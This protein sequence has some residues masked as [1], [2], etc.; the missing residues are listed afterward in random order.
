MDNGNLATK[1]LFDEIVVVIRPVDIQ[2][3][4]LVRTQT[5][6]PAKELVRV[7]VKLL[8]KLPNRNAHR[9]NPLTGPA[10]CASPG[11]MVGPQDMKRHG[12]YG[13]YAFADPLG[14]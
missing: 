10:V 7:L 1:F 11:T 6:L 14:T 9:A 8:G 4:P 12:V 2:G 5:R 3:R 13:I